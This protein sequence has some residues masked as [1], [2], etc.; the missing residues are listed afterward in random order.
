M[1]SKFTYHRADPETRTDVEGRFKFTSLPPQI[2]YLYCRGDGVYVNPAPQAGQTGRYYLGDQITLRLV[3]GGV[4]TGRVTDAFGQPLVGALVYAQRVRGLNGQPIE[5]EQLNARYSDDRGSYRIFG[6]EPGAYIIFVSGENHYGALE[7][8]SH[9]V[10][11]YHPTTGRAGATEVI[12]QSGAEVSSI[13]IQHAG[14]VGRTL[15]GTLLGGAVGGADGHT[16]VGLINPVTNQLEVLTESHNKKSFV[17]NG[18]PD[19]AYDALAYSTAF[20]NN[21]SASAPVRVQIGGADVSGVT[22]KLLPLGS[23]AGQLVLEQPAPACQRGELAFEEVGIAV[24][25]VEKGAPLLSSKLVSWQRG[26]QM[27]LSNHADGQFTLRNLPAG[28]QFLQ[29]NLPTGWYVK[30]AKLKNDA[31]ASKNT[32]NSAAANN[33]AEIDLARQG[34]SLKQGERL[35]G[36][37]VTL[38]AGAASLRSKLVAAQSETKLPSR[39]RLHLVPVEQPADLLRYYEMTGSATQFEFGNVA[40]GKYWLLAQPVHEDKTKQPVTGQLAWQEPERLKL[41][42]EAEAAQHEI[43]LQP[44]QQQTNVVSRYKG[45]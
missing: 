4:I 12:V 28:R 34:F 42:K 45:Q 2:Y 8:Q 20:D 10:T 16:W 21:S 7:G 32:T 23:L 39:F 30:A 35:Q 13:D 40:P 26:P 9:E 6:L 37:T 44:C 31:S 5:R 24:V 43:E 17:I 18:L 22:L 38:A 14:R 33:P 1:G 11:T 29:F 36:L 19:G 27:V 3:K 15:S 41:R 25:Q